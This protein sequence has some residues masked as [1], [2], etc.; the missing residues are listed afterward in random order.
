MTD[1]IALGLLGGFL[2]A[3]KTTAL[4]AVARR[5]AARGRRVALV[6]N[7]QAEA[8]VD[9]ATLARD[10]LPTVEIAG[11][12]F[13]CRFSD[14]L[15]RCDELLETVRPDLLLA[16]PVGSCADLAATVLRPIRRLYGE[17]Y[18]VLPY[19]V[20]VDP[21]R[22]A[23][24]SDPPLA[25]SPLGYLF[26]KQLDEADRIVVNKADRLDAAARATVAERL[27]RRLPATPLSFS[28]ALTGEGLDELWA[29][30]E[31]GGAGGELLLEIDYDRYADA[32]AAL[33]WLNATIELSAAEPFDAG[34]LARELLA[35]IRHQL[36]RELAEIGHVKLLVE[37]GED[38]LRLHLTR[39]AGP[40]EE[41]GTLPARITAARLTLNARVVLDPALLRDLVERSLRR[42]CNARG[43][44]PRATRL[45]SLRPGRPVP[46]L[47]FTE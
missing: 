5:Q 17:R 47:R 8:L 45:E 14:F 16:E 46:E 38:A 19:A 35:A 32:E 15:A 41:V 39:A 31:R 9:T 34:G 23:A 13:C 44:T 24:L 10:G 28:S 1:P 6:T 33:G 4:G 43:V 27:A 21:A 12:C 36:T 18:R 40:L 22:L 2:G 26:W 42:A 20:L 29:A 37:S 7:D 3:G 30:I 11:G 25:E